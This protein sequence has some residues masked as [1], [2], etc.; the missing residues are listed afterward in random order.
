MNAAFSPIIEQLNLLL[1]N[2]TKLKAEIFNGQL[3]EAKRTFLFVTELRQALE[4]LL[5]NARI[6]KGP[7]VKSNLIEYCHAQLDGEKANKVLQDSIAILGILGSPRFQTHDHNLATFFQKDIAGISDNN[8]QQE[9]DFYVEMFVE[10]I[11]SHVEQLEIS[12]RR[13]IQMLAEFKALDVQK[14]N[15]LKTI[16]KKSQYKAMVDK[17]TY[18]E[19]SRLIQLIENKIENALARDDYSNRK[20]TEA[21][22]ETG[23]YVG[24]LH[25][26]LPSPIGDH[27]IIYT[28]DRRTRT[29]TYIAIG[30]HKELSLNT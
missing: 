9:R 28:W 20:I 6:E 30:S 12:C 4:Q 25:A 13:L 22:R 15:R 21:I 11:G 23:P 10:L 14:E 26:R 2:I 19:N 17:K 5:F 3:S 8:F 7:I 18:R 27:R 1:Q 29:I 24:M 16:K